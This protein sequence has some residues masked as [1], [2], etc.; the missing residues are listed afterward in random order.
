MVNNAE[1]RRLLDPLRTSASNKIR[2]ACTRDW[3]AIWKDSYSDA[4]VSI[5]DL[6]QL[7]LHIGAFVPCDCSSLESSGNL[8]QSEPASNSVLDRQGL[9][10]NARS[11][12]V[13]LQCKHF[14]TVASRV[15]PLPSVDQ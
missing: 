2:H 8:Q 1:I 15:L 9:L 11:R 6:K 7:G 12:S 14:A 3:V 13:R 4:E 5:E 10:S